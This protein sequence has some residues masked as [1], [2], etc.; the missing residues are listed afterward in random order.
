MGLY[1][2][3]NK[4]NLSVETEVY[5]IS[6]PKSGRTWLRALIGKYLSEKYKLP[7]KYLLQTE[8][9]TSQ[10]GLSSTSFT[11]DGSSM[12]NQIKYQDL[13]QDKSEYSD[14]KVILMGRDIKDTLVSCYFQAYKRIKIFEGTISD[15]VRSEEF[16]VSK[17]VQFYKI[18]LQNKDV[19][20]SLLFLKYEYLH[21]QPVEILKSVLE[22]LDEPNVNQEYVE[23][24]I[25]YCRFENLKKA[26]K[27][28]KFGTS[29][30]RPGDAND[31]ESFKV[32][33]GKV[34]G[35]LEYLSPED[36]EFVD[37]VIENQ[38]F[39]FSRFLKQ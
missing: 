5:L 2:I 13:P 24:A 31:P 34:G 10:V 3:K 37:G 32:R 33:K 22:F 7:E 35:Y 28:N 9:I 20:K 19:P 21:E 36:I 23:S 39:S 8:N 29:D 14:R 1:K 4:L 6:Y 30:L 26:E 18:W 16:G 27:E 15:F 12:M 38:K 17:I 11:H 25:E